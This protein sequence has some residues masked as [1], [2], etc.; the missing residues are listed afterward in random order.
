MTFQCD[1]VHH[2]PACY[3]N[4]KII[5]FLR[6]FETQKWMCIDRRLSTRARD[7]AHDLSAHAFAEIDFIEKC[8]GFDYMVGASFWPPA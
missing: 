2:E 5:G 8:T 7:V 1:G 4:A 6:R 3:L